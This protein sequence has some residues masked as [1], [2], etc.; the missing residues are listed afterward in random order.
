ME[1]GCGTG[2]N[3]VWLA[4]QGFEVTGV[5]VAPLAVEQAQQR[6]SDAGVKAQFV[7]GDVLE[8]PE[9]G[10]PFGFFFDRGCYHAVRR[11]APSSTLRPWRGNWPPVAAA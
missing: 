5:D 4:Q 8:L 3:G 1:L 2:T 7:V 9:L 10:G 11:S 6:A